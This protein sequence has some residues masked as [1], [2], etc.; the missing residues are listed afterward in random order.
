MLPHRTEKMGFL[1]S[2]ERELTSWFCFLKCGWEKR[3]R[4]VLG[5]L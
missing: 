2:L 1:P 4:K 3:R 5:E